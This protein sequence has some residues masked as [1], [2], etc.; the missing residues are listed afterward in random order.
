[1]E[2]RN[3]PAHAQLFLTAWPVQTTIGVT[4]SLA[5]GFSGEVISGSH[6]KHSMH[7]VTRPIQELRFKINTK[8]ILR[9]HYLLVEI[10]LIVPNVLY[11]SGLIR[12]LLNIS[13]ALYFSTVQGYL[14]A[15][16]QAT[17]YC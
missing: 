11:S 2:S 15:G 9:I 6:P 3:R 13:Q 5:L 7:Y 4:L 12:C 10:K 14:L 8:E 1:M 17:P 16:R